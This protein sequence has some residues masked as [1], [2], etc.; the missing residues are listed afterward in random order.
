MAV[1]SRLSIAIWVMSVLAFLLICTGI[2]AVGIV[3]SRPELLRD[4]VVY[5]I[6]RLLPNGRF[7]ADSVEPSFW[8]SPGIQLKNCAFTLA[9][10]SA[11]RI[12]ALK[13]R[14]RWAAFLQGKVEVA[15]IELNRPLV[16][17]ASRHDLPRGRNPLA[18]L[19]SLIILN[20]FNGLSLQIHEGG[21]RL[22]HRGALAADA[23]AQNPM[24]VLDM[25]GIN[26]EAV[27]PYRGESG[28]LE[29]A[30]GSITQ[31]LAHSRSD[32]IPDTIKDLLIHADGLTL[33]PAAPY[34][35]RVTQADVSLTGDMNGLLKDTRLSLTLL[36]P[37]NRVQR[38]T[39]VAEGAL[40]VGG[41]Y[42][43]KN[44]HAVLP[45]PFRVHLP[46]TAGEGRLNVSDGLVK[47]EG[48]SMRLNLS[49]RHG[50]PLKGRLDITK[51]S[52]P[53]WFACVRELPGG[54]ASALDNL[55]GTLDFV[56]E[57]KS[58]SFPQLRVA[59]AGL[60]FSGK[61]SFQFGSHPFLLLDVGTSHADLNRLMPEIM[62]RDVLPPSYTAPSPFANTGR[63][64]NYRLSVRADNAKMWDVECKGMHAVV[65][66]SRND[67]T[68]L[69]LSAASLYGGTA[70]QIIE[71][72]KICRMNM[73]LSGLKAD[74]L[75]A[76]FPCLP[77]FK[78]TVDASASLQGPAGSLASL[79]GGLEGTASAK[80]HDG[81]WIL[82]DGKSVPVTEVSLAFSGKGVTPE[83][84]ALPSRLIWD[85]AWKAKIQLP[86]SELLAS[87]T[88]LELDLNG[89]VS[90]SSLSGFPEE[91]KALPLRCRG[92]LSGG[93]TS[94]SAVMSLSRSSFELANLAGTLAGCPIHGAL[95]IAPFA[96]KS[97][98][99]FAGGIDCGQLRAL[100]K[101]FAVS[102]PD[103]EPEAF[104]R[105]SLSCEAESSGGGFSVRKLKGMLD[106]TSIEG[107]ITC[108]GDDRW[109]VRLALGALNI[110]RYLPRGGAVSAAAAPSAAALKERNPAFG[111]WLKGY[112]LNGTLGAGALSY[113][114]LALSNVSASVAVDHGVLNVHPL[115]AEYCGGKIEMPFSLESGGDGAALFEGQVR[116]AELDLKK[117]SAQAGIDGVAGGKLALEMRVRSRA[118]S[119]GE[120]FRTLN[121]SWYFSVREGSMEAGGSEKSRAGKAYKVQEFS[122]SGTLEGGSADSKDIRLAGKDFS[123]LGSGS[124]NLE[125][126]IFTCS[127]N[128]AVHGKSASMSCKENFASLKRSNAGI[129]V[130]PYAIG[131]I[132]KGIA[133]LLGK[134][135]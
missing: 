7:S 84:T 21:F 124:V 62:G 55:T 1:R 63:G 30:V 5:V 41:L 53:R 121:G 56:L 36:P 11:A 67:S 14:L 99:K 111:G 44:A 106:D 49:A 33:D 86:P 114:N 89:P 80:L 120:M 61:G 4:P 95:K 127:M 8:P 105:C 88:H 6:N 23:A 118:D 42:E 58:V 10:R 35:L 100:L 77:H 15:S 50:V 2:C 98:W 38:G 46:F 64:P 78:G 26:A 28:S 31:R 96:A 45:V 24:P 22:Y 43:A 94:F 52:L 81:Q 79:V 87:P 39:L 48:D 115:T 16:D 18:F 109:N 103:Y 12:E 76:A 66:S 57:G 101:R 73:Q 60:D 40:H 72:G 126:S 82:K 97:G 130:V 13:F 91:I 3:H 71:L 135:E 9:D 123:A 117:V 74:S 29:I 17:L 25:A 110:D 108:D 65:E 93:A 102:L 107:E 19:P 69:T 129:A 47:L 70:H 75:S 34:G 85:G 122:A 92:T 68:R 27:F 20:R 83:G 131:R 113:K 51:V 32:S 116:A 133:E 37:D 119:I 112:S 90:V 132:S 104:Q 134:Y 54:L 125:D 59:V 128:A